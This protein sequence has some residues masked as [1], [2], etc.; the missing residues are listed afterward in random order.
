[1]VDT[2]TITDNNRQIHCENFS[3]LFSEFYLFD[4]LS[5]YEDLNMNDY[6]L[7]LQKF[8]LQGKVC[9]DS[10]LIDPKNFSKGQIRR[11]ALIF[12]CLRVETSSRLMSLAQIRILSFA[13]IFMMR[14]CIT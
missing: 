14:S 5:D 3:G 9:E 8:Q 7:W 10:D 13:N 4:K 6:R 11:L 1:M 2:K 12:Y